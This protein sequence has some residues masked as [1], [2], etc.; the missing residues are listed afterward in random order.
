MTATAKTKAKRRTAFFLASL[1]LLAMFFKN[2]AIAASTVGD[3]LRLCTTTLIPSLFP[4]MVASELLVLSGAID[5]LG[6]W[7]SRPCRA[8]FGMEGDAACAVLLGMLCGFPIGTRCAVTLYR[9]GRITEEDFCRV[10]ALS[11][12]PSSAF[13]L[14]TVGISLFGSLRLGILLYV[15]TLLSSLLLQFFSH[16][17][18]KKKTAEVRHIRPLPSTDPPSFASALSNAVSASAT[19]LLSICAF[20]VFFSA[21]VECLTHLCKGLSL[22]PT[23]TAFLFG[24]FEL[25][26]GVSRASLCAPEIAPY[27]CAFFVGWAGL[28][29][30]FQLLYLTADTGFP[31][32]KYFLRKLAQGVLNIPILAL[33]LRL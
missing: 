16:L 29:V 8:L 12:H 18:G 13:L 6:A 5:Q 22:S 24:I 33:L 4:L 21:L 30:H 7:L 15:T 23:V 19:A 26:G 14:S 32:S 10:L 3:A 28:S 17:L 25:T 1:F 2:S 20:V 11:N 31:K 9:E 27:L